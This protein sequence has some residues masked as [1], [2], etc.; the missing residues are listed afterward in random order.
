MSK[1]IIVGIIGGTGLDQ[2]SSLLKCKYLVPIDETPYGLASDSHA[3]SG[4]IEDVPVY[5]ISRHGKNHDINPSNVNY[6]ANLW[7]LVKQFHCT[8]LLAT[9]ACGS[10][11]DD[12]KPGNIGILDQYLDRTCLRKDRTFY[13]VIHVEQKH[14]TSKK[15]GSM[16]QQALIDNN[17][18][19][20]KDLCVVSIEGPRFSTSFESKLY[21][22]W[23][24]DVVNMTSVPEV[25]LAAE[26]G[27][28]YGC[29][30]L[31]TDYDC[32][33]DDEES[34]NATLVVE[35]MKE[36]AVKV[37]KIIPGIIKRIKEFNW[38]QEI[39]D[40]DRK[41]AQSIMIK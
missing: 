18:A 6:R 25:P 26:L 40:N 32:W 29:I 12:V 38:D 31:V 17:I 20:N 39:Q 16:I 27:V 3:V 4:N 36:L 22:S 23:G 11:K 33:K 1:K 37:R 41:V 2:D 35:R 19:F 7:A 9:S 24:C 30:M 14:P 28:I 13:K 21:R 10:L 34:V 8:H 15:L 5:I